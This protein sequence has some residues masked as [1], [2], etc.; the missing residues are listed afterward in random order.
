MYPTDELKLENSFVILVKSV[1]NLRE[2]TTYVGNYNL[3]VLHRGETPRSVA[4]AVFNKSSLRLRKAIRDLKGPT[5]ISGA[6][7]DLG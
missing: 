1:F 2:T 3:G 4:A 7:S 6:L 5:F